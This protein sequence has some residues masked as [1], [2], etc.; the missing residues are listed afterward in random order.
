MRAIATALVLALSS[1][2]IAAAADRPSLCQPGE[3][4]VFS[5]AVRG[6]K[7]ASLC[8]TSD[9]PENAGALT[10]R[11]GRPGKAELVHP[12]PGVRP[13]EAF[14]RGIIGARGGDFIRF[15][16]GG[17]TYSV[18]YLEGPDVVNHYYAGVLVHR[19]EKQFGEIKC[20]GREPNALGADG[21]ARIY[22]AGLPSEQYGLDANVRRS[23]CRAP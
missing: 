2:V 15:R 19:G 21:F 14:S 8:A 7:I 23:P 17:F 16:R 12:E 4:A 1:T 20:A 5:C 22:R 13:Q 11:F 6:G 10:Y 18:E 9:L 3:S